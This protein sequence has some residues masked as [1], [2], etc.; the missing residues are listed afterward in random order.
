MNAS[1]SSR[2]KTFTNMCCIGQNALYTLELK[3]KTCK[4]VTGN[5]MYIIQLFTRRFITRYII[6]SLAHII[7]PTQNERTVLLENDFLR[8]QICR[9]Y[10][11]GFIQ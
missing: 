6:I 7:H 9:K 8:V 5:T 1:L 2:G 10:S 3:L 11:N 4:H